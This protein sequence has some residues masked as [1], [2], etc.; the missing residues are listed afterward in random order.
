M[1]RDF[2]LAFVL[3]WAVFLFTGFFGVLSLAIA[4]VAVGL[5]TLSLTAVTILAFLVSKKGYI[6]VGKMIV[7][8]YTSLMVLAQDVYYDGTTLVNLYLF[9]IVIASL[10]IFANSQPALGIASALFA[11]LFLVLSALNILPRMQNTL[12]K[13]QVLFEQFGNV[14]GSVFFTLFAV[15]YLIRSSKKYQVKLEEKSEETRLAIEGLVAANNTKTR[16]FSIIGHDLRNPLIAIKGAVSALKEP[17]FPEEE[18]GFLLSELEKRVDYAMN[19]MNNLLIWSKAQLNGI[20]FKPENF[21]LAELI[22]TVMSQV[23]GQ[24]ADKRIDMHTDFQHLPLL[25]FADKGMMEIVIRNIIS[26]SL[27]YTH[28]GGFIRIRARKSD[29]WV[30][31]TITDS[32]VGMDSEALQKVR[33]QIFYTTPGTQ[34]EKGSGLGLMICADFLRF[35]QAELQIDSGKESG[36]RVSFSIAQMLDS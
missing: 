31:I 36:T 20:E 9:P 5:L 21:D 19:L 1:D 14:I 32:G 22:K 2:D 15:F 11:T 13:E 35:H 28:Q 30:V 18:R 17:D 24:A 23:Q 33:N 3:L 16:L 4:N 29:D 12:S 10:L 7:L 27:K 8:N 26:N 34:K 25:V 6:N